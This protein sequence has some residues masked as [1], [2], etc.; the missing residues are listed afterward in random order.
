MVLPTGDVG[1]LARW[2]ELVTE[3]RDNYV[4]F[5]VFPDRQRIGNLGSTAIFPPKLRLDMSETGP[6]VPQYVPFLASLIHKKPKFGILSRY[7]VFN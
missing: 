3:L 5:S 2:Q 6:I 4:L 7:L 1:E